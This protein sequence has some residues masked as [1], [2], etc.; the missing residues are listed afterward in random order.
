[1]KA[2]KERGDNSGAQDVAMKVW[3]CGP[4]TLPASVHF[5]SFLFTDPI[6]LNDL[7][8]EN[9]CHPLKGFIS[10]LVQAPIFIS[11][12]I[13]LRKM[14]AAPVESLT[15]GG[16]LWFPDLTQGDP[17]HVLPIIASATMLATIEVRSAL[18]IAVEPRGQA[19]SSAL[20]PLQLGSEGAQ[21]QQKMIRNIFRVLCVAMIPIT[22]DFPTAVFCYW[23]TSNT[24]SLAQL[25]LMKIPV[26]RDALKIPVKVG[27]R[28]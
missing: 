3:D 26:I 12:F 23:V 18:P 17:Y 13:G 24:F 2:L 10:P 27:R 8:M 5:F 28:V 1:M 14:A 7:F 11:F 16:G 19:G 4:P 15:T 9:K 20:P 21:A 22:W 25:S 6:Q